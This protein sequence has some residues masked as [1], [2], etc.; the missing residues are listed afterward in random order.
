MREDALGA[1][2]LIEVIVD[3]RHPERSRLG[4]YEPSGAARGKTSATM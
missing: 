1:A 3:E 2:S 4:C